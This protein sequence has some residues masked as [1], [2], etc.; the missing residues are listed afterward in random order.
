MCCFAEYSRSNVKVKDLPSQL[1]QKIKMRTLRS[2]SEDPDIYKNDLLV[3]AYQNDLL[4]IYVELTQFNV[5]SFVPAE[6]VELR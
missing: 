6:L 3:V 5:L 1:D 2:D 4:A